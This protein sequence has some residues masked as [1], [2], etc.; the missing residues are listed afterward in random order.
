MVTMV[1]RSASVFAGLALGVFGLASL[2]ALSAVAA[3]PDSATPS[4]IHKAVWPLGLPAAYSVPSQ[5]YL[6]TNYH[7]APIAIASL[8]KMMTAVVV[9]QHLPLGLTGTGPSWIVTARD[10][11]LTKAI[12]KVGGVTITVRVGEQLSEHLLLKGLLVRSANNFA[13]ML[14]ELTHMRLS[15]FVW[16]MNQEAKAL[17]MN[18]THYVDPHGLSDSDTSTP[19]DQLIVAAKME[20]YPLLRQIAAMTAVDVPIDGW[21]A[22]WTPMLGH[23]GIIGVKTGT[24]DTAGGC[25][26]MLVLPHVGRVATPVYI[27]VFGARSKDE[28]ATAGNVALT[29][30]RQVAAYIKAHP[31]T[32]TTTVPTTT[33]SSST[34]T[35]TTLTTT[36]TEV[37]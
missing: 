23:Y 30:E 16:A 5:G 2:P 11:K 18:Q 31:P 33:T 34:T 12:A 4:T 14:A 36:T 37:P 15:S 25:D 1:S 24:T 7:G 29:I 3:S 6:Q 21:V 22:T 10:V 8:T 19:T 35:T 32:T 17:G 27:A 13:V 28:L 9:E 26:V 20:T